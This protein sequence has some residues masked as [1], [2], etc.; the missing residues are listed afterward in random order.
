MAG[1]HVA[2]RVQ[3]QIHY[4]QVSGTVLARVAAGPCRGAPP[5]RPW[6]ERAGACG[7]GVPVWSSRDAWLGGVRRW[8]ESPALA[9]LCA[10]ERV[11]ISWATL[12]AVAGVMAEA[13]D[14]RT[15]RHCAIT[16]ARI[17]AA[18]GC[19]TRT[20]STA[21]R[22]LRVA[23]W[24]VEAQ[25]GHGSPTTPAEGRRPSVYHLV[26][27]RE[28]AAVGDDFHLPPE[29]VALGSSSPVRTCSPSTRA[30]AGRISTAQKSQRPPRPL[31]IQRLAAELV[32]RT[33]STGRGHIG[34]VCDA[35]ISAGI[36]PAAWSARAIT[37][38][39]D[40]D[41]RAR[42]WSWPDR[43]ERP[44][45][46][47]GHRLRRLEWRP[48]GPPNSGVAAASQDKHRAAAATAAKPAPPPTAAQRER[49]AA[50]KAEIR[51]TLAARKHGGAGQ[52]RGAD[53]TACGLASGGGGGG[54]RFVAP[55]SG[56]RRGETEVTQLLRREQATGADRAVFGG[57]RAALSVGRG[58]QLSSAGVVL[59]EPLQGSG[60]FSA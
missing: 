37:D 36:D 24:A 13:A 40:A 29:A 48:E 51:S 45:A 4:P 57:V 21:W 53:L 25:R 5:V 49:I 43:I 16:R 41:M 30:R 56:A 52:G 60:G 20:V 9:T 18:A 1:L 14:H 8:A 55:L 15:G 46:F 6:V 17:A 7:A 3:S 27:R 10:A 47:L 50:A 34:A 11:S 58:S 28:A 22:V 54:G 12:C 38:T 33:H 39:L 59:A 42:G 31:A 19:D 23:G 32:A 26:P 2:R 35:L 44:G